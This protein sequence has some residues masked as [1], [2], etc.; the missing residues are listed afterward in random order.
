MNAS[1]SNCEHHEPSHY[2]S[3]EMVS[4]FVIFGIGIIGCFLSVL[5]LGREF[6]RG[7]SSTLVIVAGL[8]WVDFAGVLSTG[9]LIIHGFV[10]GKGWIVRS[11]QCQ[12]QAFCSTACGLSS[13]SIVTF[14]AFDRAL[15]LHKPFFYKTFASPKL[16][17]GVCIATVCLCFVVAAFPYLGIGRYTVTHSGGYFCQFD[18]YSRKVMDKAFIF[19]CGAYAAAIIS[20]M[21]VSNLLVLFLSWRLKQ[22][23]CRIVPASMGIAER[24]QCSIAKKE[25]QMAKFV[26]T[27]SLLFLCTWLPV[28]VRFFC[29]LY[30]A[31]PSHTA[32]LVSM[33]LAILGFVLNPFIYVLFRAIF[34]RTIKTKF[35]WI[36]TSWN[37]GLSIRDRRMTHAQSIGPSTMLETGLSARPISSMGLVSVA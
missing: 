23:A 16:S 34:K 24:R 6:I 28:T 26:G 14:M 27:I 19:I 37:H 25:E 18:W 36:R 20:W 21:L 12:I 32:D 10:T 11:P 2:S 31:L 8:A 33:K 30:S 22:Q 3:G 9:T 4:S 35:S 1:L 29:H 17:R 13:G 7:N 15:S 5:A